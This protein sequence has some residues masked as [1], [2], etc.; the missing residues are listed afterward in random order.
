MASA[1]LWFKLNSKKQIFKAQFTCFC[2]RELHN[3]CGQPKRKWEI[4]HINH[5]YHIYIYTANTP[6]HTFTHSH[7]F[8]RSQNENIASS[9]NNISYIS[10]PTIGLKLT[11]GKPTIG[12]NYA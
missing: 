8:I 2:G 12:L 6:T 3:I 11:F 10:F 9:T 7:T 5:V 1:S 4:T